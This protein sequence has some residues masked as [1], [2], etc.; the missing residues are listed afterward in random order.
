[1]MFKFSKQVEYAL[2][3]LSHINKC[4]SQLPISVRQISDR[5]NIPYELLAK[6][7]QKLSKSHI[8]DSVKGPRGGYKL[9]SKYKK[10]N[11]IEFIEILE[12]PFGVTECLM[13]VECN[14]LSSCNIIKPLDKINSKIYQVFS[15]IK[16]NQLT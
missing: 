2:I 3:S 7:L 13:D 11:L 6:I 15:D 1:M 12:G 10:L 14:Q 4:D 5:Y 16:L 9:K 8:L